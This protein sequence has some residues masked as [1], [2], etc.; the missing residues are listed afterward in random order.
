M[1]SPTEIK[2]LVDLYNAGSYAELEGRANSLLTHCPDFGF[3]WKLLGSALQ[4]QGKNSLL[5]FRKAA[6][7]MPGE[8]EAHYNLA[9]AQ[10]SFGLLND[11]TASY[12]RALQIKP[13]YADAYYSLGNALTELGQLDEAISNYLRALQIKPDFADA[14]LKLGYVLSD[15]G[16]LNDAAASFRRASQLKPEYAD[17]YYNLGNALTELGQLDEAISNY[18]R[19][20][21]I[22]PDFADAHNK[23]G[24]ALKELGQ[25]DEAQACYRRALELRPD[26]ADVHNNL[27][28][29]F[30]QLGQFDAAVASFRVAVGIKS[31]FAEA[32]DNLGASLQSLGLHDEARTSYKRAVQLKHNLAAALND[33]G[34]TLQERGQSNSALAK[35][36]RALYLKPDFARAH[37][38]LGL[39]LLKRE[40]FFDA[41]SS[42]RRALQLNPGSADAHFN[43]GNALRNLGQNDDALASYR[44][45]LEL[46]PDFVLAQSN[47]LFTLNY[48]SSSPESGLE[49]AWKYGRM[50]EKKV[51]SRYS[52]WLCAARPERLRVG[53][54]SGDLYQHPVVYFLEALLTQLD[55]ACIELIAYSTS[56]K[57]DEFTARIKSYFA[58][59][60]PIHSL[61]DEAAARLIHSDGV[62]IL[63][64]LSGHTANNRLPVFAWKPAPVQVSW[65]GYFATTGVTEMDYLLADKVGV[66]EVQREHFTESIWYLPDTRLCFT[67]PGVDLPVTPL[68]ALANGFITFGCFQNMAKLCDDVLEAWGEILAAL[69]NARLRLQT[70]QL[71]KTSQVE[72][73][74]QR[75][76]R[77][78]IDPARVAVHGSAR[79]D[80]YLAAHAEV[81]MILDTFPYPGG[82]TT[83]EA[84]WMGV[85]TL[86]LAGDSLLA[87]QGASLLSAA[88]LEE[89]VTTSKAEYIAKAI[90]FAADQSSLAS[91]RAGLRQKVLASPLFDAPRFTRHFEDTM[92]GMWQALEQIQHEC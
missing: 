3:G 64:D 32:Y 19:A 59:L 74:I 53:I 81:D 51:T 44:K 89:W 30:L 5:A 85:P 28:M 16:Q 62:H 72:Q 6:E 49:E 20:L 83:C 60:K 39:A 11:A 88:E 78:G 73:L 24:V 63:I 4:M 66:P 46:K 48:I 57:F 29:L 10:K 34:V 87:R 79:R 36:R 45:A 84:L 55:P 35:F 76:Q 21:Q 25:F 27:G 68:P 17:A 71:D 33:L 70:Y 7:L 58:A 8:A 2:Q 40:Q 42:F 90:T 1:L 26:L 18:L 15:L 86:T 61:S 13:E 91:L 14:H 67:A 50:V 23:L 82:T 92:R 12:R 75:L 38:N 22:K 56:S 9:T 43:L 31:D 47:L 54:V 65:L 80:A 69:P 77:Y 41:A 37:N 52:S